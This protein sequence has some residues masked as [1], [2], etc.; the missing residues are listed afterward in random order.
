[1]AARLAIF[2]PPPA[3]SSGGKWVV[4]AQFQRFIICSGSN[5]LGVEGNACALAVTVIELLQAIN[6]TSRMVNACG[7]REEKEKRDR[8]YRLLNAEDTTRSRW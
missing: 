1:M 3:S 4:D 2:A 8:E 5:D 6:A 7:F